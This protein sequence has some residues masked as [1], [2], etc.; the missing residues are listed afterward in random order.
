MSKKNTDYSKWETERL[1]K[2]LKSL[3]FAISLLAGLL[4]VLLFTTIYVSFR[5]RQ[6]NPLLITPIAL[7][8]I[9][10]LNVRQ[11][12]NLKAEIERRNAQ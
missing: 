8:I 9:I 11:M 12:K 5:D 4:L 2:Q 6:L 1:R 7:S 3:R 10:P